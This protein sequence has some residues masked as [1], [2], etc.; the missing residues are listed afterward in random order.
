M[1]SLP[2]RLW[3]VF[4]AALAT[5]W[6]FA[7]QATLPETPALVP[8]KLQGI[9]Y[10]AQT[11]D[12][13]FQGRRITLAPVAVSFS[14]TWDPRSFGNFG[15]DAAEVQKIRG[16]LAA[17]ATESF[18]K[19]LASTQ[20][21]RTTTL[22]SPDTLAL[23]PLELKI[24]IFDVYVNAPARSGLSPLYTLVF[25][26]GEMSIEIELR[27]T[28][29]GKVLAALRDRYRD[30]GNATLTLSNEISQ[31]LATKQIFG[32]WAKQFSRLLRSTPQRP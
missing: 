6:M 30:P 17:I 3:T 24:R 1:N 21:S 2:R 22:A 28:G 15:L 7:S 9:D 19:M 8:V 13:Y 4:A 16:D 25:E 23:D 12:Q 31:R 29:S 26:S 32:E 11:P 10:A 5:G 18:T 14:K 20:L 27:E